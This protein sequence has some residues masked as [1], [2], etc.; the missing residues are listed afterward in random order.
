MQQ[1]VEKLAST[2][3]AVRSPDTALAAVPKMEE[4]FAQLREL[5]KEPLDI[6]DLTEKQSKT[7]KK[8]REE[9][10]EAENRLKRAIRRLPYLEDLPWEFWY[11]VYLESAKLLVSEDHSWKV[12]DFDINSARRP[13]YR[14]VI[15]TLEAEDPPK[16]VFIR[17]K[18]VPVQ[19]QRIALEYVGDVLPRVDMIHR[20]MGGTILEICV[21]PVD[22][23]Q[24]VVTALDIGK[25]AVENP[26]GRCVEVDVIPWK[27]DTVVKAKRAQWQKEQEER[28][29][30][31][32]EHRKRWEAKQAEREARFWAERQKEEEA[33]RG[34][35]RGDPGYYDHQVDMLL[36]GNLL[37]QRDAMAVL[38]ATSPE[39]VE[40]PETR[41]RIARAFR[42][43][44]EGGH[45]HEQEQAIRGLVTWGG[46]Y[47]TPILLK[48]FNRSIGFRRSPLYEAF[49]EL[50]DPAVVPT[51]M[52]QLGNPMEHK[53]A[54]ECLRQIGPAAEDEVLKWVPSPDPVVCL[55]AI[56][57]LSELGTEK[58]LPM[59]RKASA[60]GNP[61]IKQAAMNAINQ[62]RFR[63]SQ[64]LS[65]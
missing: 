58:S 12:L 25:L 62:I 52:A 17:L 55:K 1:Q 43:I 11:A 41:K 45:M 3:E 30:E 61:T 33:E 14:E 27:L 51:V 44:A 34:P 26:S 59:L 21:S 22:D 54:A 47:S 46:K 15:K 24:S 38:L 37:E 23:F 31:L 4:I 16:L 35:Q 29:P 39:E 48:M 36:S 40:S 9:L 65:P 60:R 49:G 18:Q 13:Y 63:A 64:N 10:T 5:T 57:V 6:S 50:K 53:E 20:T 2:L 56:A 8:A 42:S 7:L 19:S 28:Y 32:A